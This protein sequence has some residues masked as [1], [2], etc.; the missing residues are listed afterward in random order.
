MFLFQSRD[1]VDVYSGRR[2]IRRGMATGCFNPA[3]G[4]MF[5]PAGTYI[6]EVGDA[7]LF[8]SRDWVDV[9]SG[10]IR[11]FRL[12]PARRF[13]SRDWVDVYSGHLLARRLQMFRLVSIP[14]LG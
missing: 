14:R 12:W 7:L 4:L 5:I 11:T 9:Y 1:W 3:T 13:Q 6:G 2:S 8:Q 10:L